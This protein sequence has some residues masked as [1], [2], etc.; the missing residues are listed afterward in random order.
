MSTSSLLAH[1]LMICWSLKLQTIVLML[2]LWKYSRLEAEL[3]FS[4][5]RESF[6]CHRK[7]IE[8]LKQKTIKSF[9]LQTVTNKHR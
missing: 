5:S 7:V 3:S 9:K 1:I 6:R 4:I 2:K 8:Y